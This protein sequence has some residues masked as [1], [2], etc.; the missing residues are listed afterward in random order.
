MKI[1]NVHLVAHRIE[2]VVIGRPVFKA[3]F[4]AAACQPH[5][6]P[7]GIV[8]APIHALALHGGRTPKFPAPH[9]QRVIEQPTCLE[10]LEQ[11]GDGFIHLTGLFSVALA[12]VAVLIPLHLVITMGHLHKPNAALGKTAGHQA[13]STKILGHRLVQPVE[14]A[15]GLSLT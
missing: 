7:V 1:V 4:H 10:V 3:G 15:C 12:Q 13:L 2:T 9:H 11:A 6:K 8:V 5:G 14:I